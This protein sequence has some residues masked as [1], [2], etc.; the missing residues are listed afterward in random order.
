MGFLPVIAADNV[1][2]RYFSNHWKIFSQPSPGRG[3]PVGVLVHREE[4]VA[5]AVSYG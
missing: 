2:L 4:G 3:G 1:Q 5:G